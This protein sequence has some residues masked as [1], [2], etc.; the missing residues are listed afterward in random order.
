MKRIFFTLFFPLILGFAAL[1]VGINNYFFYKNEEK[2]TLMQMER[3]VEQLHGILL[4]CDE[5]KDNCDRLMKAFIKTSS[6]NGKILLK[7]N[8]A[9]IYTQNLEK[10]KDDR[11]PVQYS[12][13]FQVGK[14]IFNL[15]FEK[16]VTPS[17]LVSRLPS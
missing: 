9:S 1:L 14:N 8:N 7:K 16:K 15:Y 11:S 12:T 17:I 4:A 13:K 2:Q 3:E 10:Y 5:F 6:I